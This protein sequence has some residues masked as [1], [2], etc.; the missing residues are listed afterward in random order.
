MIT[1]SQRKILIVDDETDIRNVLSILLSGNGYTVL[2]APDAYAA[3]E[4]VKN[5]S[6]IDLVV[7]DIMMPGLSGIEAIKSIRR[8]SKV[9]VLFLTAKTTD[10]DKNEAY[11]NGGDDYLSKPFSQNELLL[12]VSSLIRRYREYNPSA[13][14]KSTDVIESLTIDTERRKVFKY[15]VDTGLTDT[16][17]EMLCYFISCRGTPSDAK[18]IY[19]AVWGEKYLPSAAN[20]VM[21][22]I[23][24]LRR[25]IE[26]DPTQ[27]SVIKTVWGK[28]YQIDK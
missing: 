17:Y 27:P 23:L 13:P 24:N 20:T 21:V 16:E 1:V 25:K 10:Y 14:S 3:V 6:D 15:G 7:M 12:K 19:E 2:Q 5:N 28:G 9:P 18:A 4:T 26:D 8:F 22:H 11:K